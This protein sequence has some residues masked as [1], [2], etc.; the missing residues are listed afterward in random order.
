MD[1]MTCIRATLETGNHIIAGSKYV[2]DLTFTLVSPLETEH[3]INFL[4]IIKSVNA[5]FFRCIQM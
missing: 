1:R 3:Y 5:T 2:N 4:H